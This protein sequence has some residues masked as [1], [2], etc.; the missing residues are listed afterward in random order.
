MPLIKGRSKKS[1]EKN[2][3]TELSE[4]KP[5]DQSLA[6]AYS[7]KR[8]SPKKMAEGG[9]IT[10][11]SSDSDELDMIKGKASPSGLPMSAKSEGMPTVDS[12]TPEELQMIHRHRMAQGGMV[13]NFKDEGMASIDSDQD[14]HGSEMLDSHPTM[15]RKEK[16]WTAD[17][18]TT[19]DDAND[20]RDEHMIS[21]NRPGRSQV[22][23]A[24][25]SRPSADDSRT[26]RDEDML[27]QKPPR[28]GGWSGSL[29]EDEAEKDDYNT[30]FDLVSHIMKKRKKFAEGGMVDL[31]KN[32]NEEKNNEDDLSYDAIRKDTY[33][34]NDQLSKQPMD[35]NEHGDELSD[36]DSHDMVGQIRKR[37]KMRK[38]GQ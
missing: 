21:G 10:A 9:R 1:F 14:Q 25:T 22:P 33:Y 32:A 2:L 16:D 30:D 27:N 19:I 4:G 5:K 18:H 3:K 6:I 36:E 17:G 38:V 35:S 11:D 20:D 8:K 34:D 31:Q 23:R 15:G 26:D 37:M 24:A 28:A 7:I 29:D 12:I 13:P